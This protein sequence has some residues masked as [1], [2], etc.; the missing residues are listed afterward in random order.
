VNDR[1]RR[2]ET[3]L[4]CLTL[5]LLVLY[6]PLE[7]WVSLPY[8]LTNPF[9]LVDL[10][11]MVLLLAGAMHSLR[12]RPSPAPGLLCAAIA[13]TAANGWRATFRRLAELREGGSLDYGVPEMWAV[14]ISTAISL[15]GLALAIYLVVRADRRV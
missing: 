12:A 14:A 9:Y 8:G 2:L 5:A 4:A 1:D 11:A 3:G 7:T 6:V 10:I 15:G 13:W